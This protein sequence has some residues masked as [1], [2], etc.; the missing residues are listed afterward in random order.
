MILTT[1][2]DAPNA[3]VVHHKVPHKGDEQLFWDISNLEAVS[4]EWHDS[5][6]Q[7]E[8]RSCIRS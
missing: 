6:G 3:A 5:E 4:K 8:D 7:R 1:G 2:R